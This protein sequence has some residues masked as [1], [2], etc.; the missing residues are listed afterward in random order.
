MTT[1]ATVATTRKRNE[2]KEYDDRIH[3]KLCLGGVDFVREA[4]DQ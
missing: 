3:W 1:K 4:N 2:G